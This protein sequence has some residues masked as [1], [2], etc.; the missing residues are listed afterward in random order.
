[1][2]KHPFYWDERMICHIRE[3]RLGTLQNLGKHVP[4]I[5]ASLHMSDSW[6]VVKLA[7]GIYP[8]NLLSTSLGCQ[9]SE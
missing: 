6:L 8:E 9:T 7:S 3:I 4:E 5:L 2:L 1:M